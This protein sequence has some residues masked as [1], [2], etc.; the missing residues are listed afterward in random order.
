[1]KFGGIWHKMKEEISRL[2]VRALCGAYGN[3]SRAEYTLTCR[4]RASSSISDGKCA[5]RQSRYLAWRGYGACGQY[6]KRNSHK[7]KKDTH[8]ECPFYF[9]EPEYYNVE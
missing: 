3:F 5:Y 9:G 4:L 6:R 1:M 2:E 8:K 7:R